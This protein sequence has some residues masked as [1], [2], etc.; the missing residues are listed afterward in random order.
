MGWS[1]RELRR[2]RAGDGGQQPLDINMSAWCGKLNLFSVNYE[3]S[4]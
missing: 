4:S 2:L 1:L 3:K